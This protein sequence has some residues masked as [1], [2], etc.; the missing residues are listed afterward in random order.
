VIALKFLG[1]GAVAPFTG[2]RWPVGGEWVS[3]LPDRAEVWI[4]ACRVRDLPYWI[5]EEL[6]RV[7]LGAPVREARYQ[8]ASPRGR[9]VERVETW[10]SALAREFAVACAW[11]ARDVALPHLP[12][13]LH[14]AMAGA[15][16]LE[17]IAALGVP[18]GSAAGAYLADTA[19]YAQRALPAI[20]SY[21]AAALASSFGGGLPAFEAERA[22]QAGWL[23]EQ[24]GL[25][26]GV[27]L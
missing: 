14:D 19:R 13:A 1:A 5:D 26:Q 22:W 15:G 9:L 6:W 27:R 24:L 18:P 17:A 8:I 21:I 7:E 20:T 2:F 11:R 4:H 3:A 16:S 12:P 10:S 23:A 25:G